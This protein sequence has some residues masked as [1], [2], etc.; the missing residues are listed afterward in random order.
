MIELHS[1]SPTTMMPV[2]SMSYCDFISN[3]DGR[4]VLGVIVTGEPVHLLMTNCNFDANRRYEVGLIELNMQSQSTVDFVNSSLCNNSGGSLL[5]LQL[6]SANLNISLHNIQA[7]FN[8]GTS[9]VRRGGL[10]V[11]RVFE[12]NIIVKVSKLKFQNN[13]FER[14]GGGVYI[15]GQ[16]RSSFKLYL[17]DSIFENNVGQSSG[18]VIYSY[19]TSDNPYLISIYNSS[20]V[21]NSGGTSIVR[22]R[23]RSLMEDLVIVRKPAF[24]LLGQSTKFSG[25][26]GGSL[27][28]SN[29]ILVG[30][31]NTTFEGNMDNNG[32]ALFLSDA[33]ILPGITVFQ[34]NFT[35]NFA[36]V[37]GGAIYIDLSTNSNV[38]ECNWL[39]KIRSDHLCDETN[40]PIADGCPVID[41]KFLCHEMT[42]QPITNAD[43]CNFV[44]QQNNASVAGN[45]IYYQAPELPAI[46]NA[47]NPNSTFYIPQSSICG[48][49][50]D[51]TK[52]ISTQPVQLRLYEPAKCNDT[53]PTDCKNYNITDVMLG[54]EMEIPAKVVGYNNKSAESTIFF[55]KC[56]DDCPT[57]YGKNYNITGINPILI[58]DMFR[59]I[60][61]T[62][63]QNG[64]PLKLQL[65]STT[66][67][68]NL[69]IELI[70]CRSGYTYNKTSMQC[71]C[72]TTDGIVSCKP[73]PTI[74][75][76][77]WFGMVDNT[78]TVS[79][80]PY[81]YCNFRRREVSPGRFVL[82]SVQD[83]QCDS[84]RTGPACGSCDDGYTLP[85]DSIECINVDNCHPG[86]TVLVIIGVMAYWV[87]MIVVIFFSLLLLCRVKF[88]IGYLYGIIY[89]YSVVDVLLGEIV[90]CSD[91]LTSLVQVFGGTIF[92][93]YPGFLYK[94]CFLEGMDSTE[95]SVIH[96]LHPMAV[97]VLIWL[98]SQFARCSIKFAHLTG[99]VT[100]PMIILIIMLGYMP[101][102]NASLQ[103]LQFLHYEEVD[104]TYV[105]LSPK[106]EYFT[107]RHIAYFFIAVFSE[108]MVG[109]GLPL[110][111]LLQSFLNNTINFIRFK[112][113]FNQ[114]Q[115]C[116][117]DRFH[118]FASTYL[119][120]R[121]AI[122]IIIFVHFTDS[123]I[124]QYLL[125]IICVTV[126][127]LH[128]VLQPYKSS[129][130]NKFDGI[131]LYTLLL[132]VSLRLIAFSNGFTTE[133]TV[134]ITYVLYFFPIIISMFFIFHYVIVKKF[135]AEQD[136]TTTEPGA[137]IPKTT[138][139]VVYSHTSQTT[140]IDAM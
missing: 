133:A 7:I 113:L 105:Y 10:M 120:F 108:L 14:K 98:L 76:D 129:A 32:A 139:S 49:N 69:T 2:L 73:E 47:S 94:V 64:P 54:E 107:G 85:F 8:D 58:N 24:L 115:G 34:F 80:C 111:L 83:D 27:S 50:I 81:T 74:R 130:L 116:Y 39:L 35:N 119:L 86:Y 99:N 60:A 71:E 13:R 46:E 77:Y 124:E 57:N 48:D 43:S 36:F 121:Q 136:N 44:F 5:Y 33:Y 138:R 16:F 28:L 17:Q 72:Y 63:I 42:P 123:Y 38:T 132:I 22:I 55:V 87:I 20:F 97:L 110:L 91:G 140:Y 122:L 51:N 61:I 53:I 29:T 52:D 65:M 30:N 82:P 41:G 104:G 12:D 31:K 26:R 11:F 59:G 70:P 118:W 128:Y 88:N 135:I 4:N 112:P 90:H 137:S 92:K 45:V 6:R 106:T 68:L 117:K 126:A 1:L 78:T 56:I 93:L 23:K 79:R 18:I 66:I 89:Y 134:G 67:T 103:L 131:I 37:R 3:S 9:V 84:H 96:Y 15:I 125:M 75:R 114:F 127:L 21:S 25:N 62:G 19:L 109:I 40:I 100:I 101:I 95:Q 102:S